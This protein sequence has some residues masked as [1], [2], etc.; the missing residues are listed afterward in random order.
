MS[1]LS[2]VLVDCR[3][4][5]EVHS[6]IISCEQNRNQ[7][8]QLLALKNAVPGAGAQVAPTGAPGR[9][10]RN[11]HGGRGTVKLAKKDVKA[12]NADIVATS[13]KTP[14]LRRCFQTRF[15]RMNGIL[16]TRTR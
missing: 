9:N 12:E 14:D 6:V 10:D 13:A 16:F 11:S 2:A 4:K 3:A 1:V 5:P 7:Y 15:V 8:S